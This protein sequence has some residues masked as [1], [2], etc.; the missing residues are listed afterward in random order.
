MLASM[1][2]TSTQSCD[3][4]QGRVRWYG[5]SLWAAFRLQMLKV[6]CLLWHVKLQTEAYVQRQAT[7]PHVDLRQLC[8]KQC[9]FC[10]AIFVAVSDLNTAMAL[11]PTC[12]V[13]WLP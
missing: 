6:C 9:L 2:H 10:M 11:Q 8:Q 5:K 12:D 3:W 7:R 1:V 4:P 13:N